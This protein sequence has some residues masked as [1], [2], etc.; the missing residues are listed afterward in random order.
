MQK[1]ATDT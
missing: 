1:S